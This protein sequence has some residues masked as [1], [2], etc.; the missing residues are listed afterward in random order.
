MKCPKCSKEMT[1]NSPAEQAEKQI[2]NTDCMVYD[3]APCHAR[4]FIIKK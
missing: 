4:L 3:C 1:S 2:D